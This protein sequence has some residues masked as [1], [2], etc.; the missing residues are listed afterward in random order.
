MRE[1]MGLSKLPSIACASEES[2]KE[3]QDLVKRTGFDKKAGFN[4]EKGKLRYR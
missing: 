3:F 2:L 1:K 4:W